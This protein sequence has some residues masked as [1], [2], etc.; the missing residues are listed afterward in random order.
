M[1][2]LK[3]KHNKNIFERNPKKTLSIFIILAFLI[4]DFIS[5]QI[6]LYNNKDRNRYFRTFHSYYHHTLRPNINTHYWWN[7]RKCEIIT[8]SLGF[9]DKAQEKISFS[10]SKHRII[11]IGDSFTEGLGVQFDSTFVGILKNNYPDNEILNAGVVSYSP[12]LYYLKIKYLIEEKH[13]Q[14]DELYV[15]I[16]ISDIQD[17]IA[18]KDFMPKNSPKWYTYI[19]KEYITPYIKNNSLI[20]N[21]LFNYYQNKVKGKKYSYERSAWM[22]ND[23][24]Y[25]KW[26]K[27]GVNL[28]IQ[29][30]KKLYELC[31][32]NKIKMTIAIYP[33]NEQIKQKDLECRQVVIWKEFTDKYKINFIN[34]F[35]E[36]ISGNKTSNKNKYFIDGDIHWNEKGHKEIAEKIISGNYITDITQK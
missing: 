29:N 1:E 28:A 30:M 33:W 9:K 24:I 12:K 6:F 27:Q 34:Y 5:A 14:F 8:N 32:K 20:I 23:E 15:F 10:K 26:G 18:Y 3:N 35:P 36:F 21:R 17:E 7:D 22:Y 4:I 19:I 16:D 2:K 31:E 13:L 11:F 25:N